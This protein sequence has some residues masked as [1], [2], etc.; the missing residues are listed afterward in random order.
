MVFLLV[1]ALSEAGLQTLSG[2]IISNDERAEEDSEQATKGM[3]EV[4]KAVASA[5]EKLVSAL[6]QSAILTRENSQVVN[7]LIQAALEGSNLHRE[8]GQGFS[9]S[10]KHFH[11]YDDPHHANPLR[12][13]SLTWLGR[14][15]LDSKPIYSASKLICRRFVLQFSLVQQSTRQDG[16]TAF[17]TALGKPAHGTSPPP[18]HNEPFSIVAEDEDDQEVLNYLRAAANIISTQIQGIAGKHSS[19]E[20]TDEVSTLPSAHKY[21][22]SSSIVRIT[23][24]TA[25]GAQTQGDAGDVPCFLWGIKATKRHEVQ[26]T[27]AYSRET[28]NDV[29]LRTI[30]RPPNWTTFITR[31][32]QS[33]EPGGL[34]VFSFDQLPD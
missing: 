32:V 3:E 26:R 33:Q 10:Q 2:G 25:E 8:I 22:Q 23:L 27:S 20:A 9:D 24:A 29:V 12:P 28:V 16:L 7:E 14:D 15:G 18:Y 4:S 13:K 34:V 17:G 30:N 21:R 6:N 19:A 5:T 11:E 1:Q 31:T